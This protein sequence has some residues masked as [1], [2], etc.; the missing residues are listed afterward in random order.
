M[1]VVLVDYGVGNL[2]S[3]RR[4][5]SRIGVQTTISSDPATVESARWLVLP[6]VGHFGES[7][8]NLRGRGL[9]RALREALS[10]GARL[11]GIC[12][13]FQMLFESSEEAPGVE[14]LGLL[15]G[16]VKRFPDGVLSP[17]IGW[18]QLESV[19]A[20]GLLSEIAE[21]DFFYFLHSYYVA[22]RLPEIV[23]AMTDYG[24]SFSSVAGQGA[25]CGIQFHPEKSQHLGLKVLA[26]FLG[27]S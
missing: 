8:K 6:G 9:E 20:S 21:G 14:G 3:V 24:L 10:R 2:G 7:M 11:L 26:N 23:W 15:P 25:V 18:N 16:E 1:R 5:F 12:V 19:R 13:G 27:A 17:H 22:P 4:A